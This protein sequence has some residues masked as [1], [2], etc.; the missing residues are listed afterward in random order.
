METQWPLVVFTFFVCMSSGVLATEAFLLY[1]GKAQKLMMPSLIVSAVALVIG[2]LGSFTHLQHWE[3]I[4]NGFGH[5]TSGIT[6]E[7]IGCV[8]M[9]LIMILWFVIW[10]R[11]KEIT[12]PVAIITIIVCAVMVVT[13]GHS[14]MMS[15]RPAWTFVLVYYIGNAV[16]L[17]GVSMWGIITLRKEDDLQ[18]TG[19]KLAFWGGVI[20]LGTTV[21]FTICQLFVNVWD[22]G[23]YADPTAMTTAPT[24]VSS[25]F[26]EI[27]C[28]SA[29]IFFWATIV[30]GV[31]LLVSV[32]LSKKKNEKIKPA[33]YPIV[34]IVCVFATSVFMR[35]VI[36]IIGYAMYLMF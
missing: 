18:D 13:T 32:Y 33:V 20:G 36:Y 1:K 3:R 4:F 14:Y 15:A 29:A 27:V 26:G 31:L 34:A 19:K 23:Y 30:T 9:G 10:Y 6:Q 24:H 17:G 8:L 21:L 5:I 7:I 22:F 16:M 35:I 28:G 12:K 11:K 25:L 2:G